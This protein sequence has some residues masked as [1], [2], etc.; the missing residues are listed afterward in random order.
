MFRFWMVGLSLWALALASAAEE[1]SDVEQ[2]VWK[3]TNQTRSQHKLPPLTLDPVLSEIARGHAEEMLAKGFFGHESP[4]QL[5]RRV[6]DRLKHGYRF[7]LYSA[8]NLHK[9]QGYRRPQLAGMALQSWQESSSHRRN[10]LNPQ[11]GRIGVGVVQHGNTTLFT[12]VFSYEPILIETL[13][14]T[15]EGGGYQ[16]KVTARVTDG[17]KVG[18][19]FVNG[20]R[21]ADWEADAKGAFA[22]TL[23]LPSPGELDVGQADGR[24]NWSVQ[25]TIPIP[26]PNKHF[27]HTSFNWSRVGQWLRKVVSLPGLKGGDASGPHQS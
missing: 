25:T 17:P 14:V 11:Y 20:K 13:D 15:E 21:K 19:W 6:S 4:N 3:L 1:L 5:C 10:L 2:E 27:R 24:M 22:T 12:Q 23:F 16:V 8:E 26:P 18:G 7:C 9:C